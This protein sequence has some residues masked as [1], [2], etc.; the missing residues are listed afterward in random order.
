M[1]GQLF[2]YA[3]LY[4]PNLQAKAVLEGLGAGEIEAKRSEVLVSPKCVVANSADEV[5]TLAARE[6]PELYTEKIDQIEILVRPF[7]A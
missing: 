7:D 3:I 4:H 5:R 2:E 1:R 6:V